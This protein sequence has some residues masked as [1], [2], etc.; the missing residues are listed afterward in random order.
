MIGYSVAI[1]R[2]GDQWQYLHSNN[3]RRLLLC[4]ALIKTYSLAKS[5]QNPPRGLVSHRPGKMKGSML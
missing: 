4:G 5:N 2:Q 3:M 1:N